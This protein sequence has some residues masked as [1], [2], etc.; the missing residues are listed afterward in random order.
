VLKVESKQRNVRMIYCPYPTT[1]DKSADWGEGNIQESQNG[2]CFLKLDD[3]GEVSH[4]V[5]SRVNFKCPIGWV[6]GDGKDL[7]HKAPIFIGEELWVGR[8]Y[9]LDT[10]DGK[11]EYEVKE[12]SFLCYNGEDSPNMEDV[13]VQTRKNLIANYDFVM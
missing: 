2:A 9:V 4:M 3:K 1:I 5:Q 11:M 13:Y 12:P 8:T 10:L 6:I 7:Y